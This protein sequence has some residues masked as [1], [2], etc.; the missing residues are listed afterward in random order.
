MIDHKTKTYNNIIRNQQSKI[1]IDQN[2]KITNFQKVELDSRL[3]NKKVK[4]IY[5]KYICKDWIQKQE[6]V[7]VTLKN[8]DFILII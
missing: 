2:Q 4:E 3:K 1:I 5:K 7:E 6:E 8:I